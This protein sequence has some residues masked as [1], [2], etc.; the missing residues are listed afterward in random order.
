MKIMITTRRNVHHA[1]TNFLPHHERCTELPSAAV[2]M[3]WDGGSL[4]ADLKSGAGM[5]S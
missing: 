3:L 2:M 5:T 4:N 1:V